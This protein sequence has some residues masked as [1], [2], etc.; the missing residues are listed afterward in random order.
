MLVSFFIKLFDGSFHFQPVQHFLF[1]LSFW[2]PIAV[3]YALLLSIYAQYESMFPAFLYL[4]S[5]NYQYFL[6]QNLSLCGNYLFLKVVICRH[7][8]TKINKKNSYL[9]L[10]WYCLLVICFWKKYLHR[11]L[12]YSSFIYERVCAHAN[13]SNFMSLDLMSELKLQFNVPI[14]CLSLWS[15]VCTYSHFYCIFSR[16]LVVILSCINLIVVFFF[17]LLIIFFTCSYYVIF[18]RDITFWAWS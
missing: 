18:Y 12:H 3:L 5:L 8:R 14:F 1:F 9:L 15:I 17:T 2:I 16:Q 6:Q 4:R 11:L 7:V 10:L 13:W